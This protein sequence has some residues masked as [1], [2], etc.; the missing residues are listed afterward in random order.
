MMRLYTIIKDETPEQYTFPFTLWTIE[1]IR[2][3]LRRVFKVSMSGVSVW[4]TLKALGMSAQRPKHAAYQQKE[5]AVQEF[6]KKS[7]PEIKKEAKKCGAAVYWDDESAIRSDYHSGTTRVPKGQ[8]LV[9]KT[10][11]ARFSVNMLSAISDMG[12]M[13]FMVQT[14]PVR[15]RYS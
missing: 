11:G 13:R 10:T 5:E 15:Y 3:V 2:E 12:R 1:I 9:I 7:Y 6:L 14:R 4:R 8:T